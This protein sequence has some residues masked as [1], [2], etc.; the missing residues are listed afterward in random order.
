MIWRK[1]RA[2][3]NEFQIEWLPFSVFDSYSQFVLL[4]S[5]NFVL[6]VV[7][8]GNEIA[9][10]F[11]GSDGTYKNTRFHSSH[12]FELFVKMQYLEMEKSN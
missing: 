3:P 7:I 6:D 1:H 8:F 10:S 4:L 12:E 2:F 5:P 11:V 9:V